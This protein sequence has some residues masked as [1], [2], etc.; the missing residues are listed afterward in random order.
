[1]FKAS[2]GLAHVGTSVASFQWVDPGGADF[3]YT[4]ITQPQAPP[5]NGNVTIRLTSG[6]YAETVVGAF[7]QSGFM[8]AGL[9]LATARQAY[10]RHGDPGD[11]VHGCDGLV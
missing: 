10:R 2:G 7:D 8:N 5:P 3:F 6:T 11:R 1:V 9:A 4:Y